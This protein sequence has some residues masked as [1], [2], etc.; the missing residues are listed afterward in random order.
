M[1][2][3]T[4]P[5]HRNRA[6]PEIDI[7]KSQDGLQ[8]NEEVVGARLPRRRLSQAKNDKNDNGLS[9]RPSCS[10]VESIPE[11]FSDDDAEE[12]AEKGH[13]HQWRLAD[14]DKSFGTFDGFS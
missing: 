1:K 13:S 6:T 3:D 8:R 12:K 14:F 10:S 11:D 7:N 5:M 2:S 9:R 4:D